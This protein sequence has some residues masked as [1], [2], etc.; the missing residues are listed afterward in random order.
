MHEACQIEKTQK[1]IERASNKKLKNQLF[2][3]KMQKKQKKLLTGVVIVDITSLPR[4]WDATKRKRK[5]LMIEK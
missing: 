5:L 4:R 1:I 2:M 3:K